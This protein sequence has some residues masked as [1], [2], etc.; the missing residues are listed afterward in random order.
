MFDRRLF[1]NF[2]WG[3]ILIT[4]L[5]GVLGLG[6]L[7]SAVNAGDS[8]DVKHVLFQKQIIWITGSFIIVLISLF[9]P[10]K[11]FH[12]GSFMLVLLENTLNSQLDKDKDSTVTDID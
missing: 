6:V 7:Y 9:V 8:G 5:I 11:I 10:Y 12:K 3:L 4:V 1:E 2:D